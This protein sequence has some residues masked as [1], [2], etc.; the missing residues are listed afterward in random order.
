M[1][2]TRNP[3][4]LSLTL[5]AALWVRVALDSRRSP[6]PWRWSVRWGWLFL[7]LAGLFNG[8]TIHY[9]STVLFRLPPHGPLWGAT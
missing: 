3:L 4:Y 6:G 8:L 1:L 5:L 9:G 2:L 7:L